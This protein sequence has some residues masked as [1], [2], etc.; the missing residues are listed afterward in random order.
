MSD[1]PPCD[2][3]LARAQQYAKDNGFPVWNYCPTLHCDENV[4][5]NHQFCYCQGMFNIPSNFNAQ[6][7][8]INGV[9]SLIPIASESCYCCCSC[10]AFDTPI[11][12]SKDM[13]KAVQNFEVNDLVWVAA[14]PTLKSWIQKPVLFS[15]GTGPDG[16]NKL[17]KVHFGDQTKGIVV[18]PDSFRSSFVSKEMSEKYFSILSTNKFIDKG[19]LVDLMAVKKSDAD[20][21]CK[22]LGSQMVVAQKVFNILKTDSNYLLVTGIQPFLMKDKTLKQAQKLVP[23][24]DVLMLAD[25]STTPIISLELGMFHKGVHHIATSNHPATSL[26]GHLLLANGIVVGDYATQLSMGSAKSSLK[27]THADLPVFG[28]KEYSAKYN[29]LDSTSFSA[30]AKTPV[31]H[32]AELFE[33]FHIAKSALIPEDAFSF[34]TKDQSEELM[35]NAPIYPASNNVAEPDVRYLFKLFGAFNPDITY[36]Y[37]QNNMIPNAYSFNQYGSKFVVINCGWTLLE[38]I[39]FQGIAMTIAHL[40]AALNEDGLLPVGVSPLGKADYDVYPVFLS[41]FY[42]PQAAVLNYNAASDQIKKIFSYIKKHRDPIDEISL[43]CRIDTLAASIKGSPL[44]HCAG[45]PPNPAL[46]VT[47]ASATIPEGHEIP[48]I[49]ITFNMPVDEDTASALGNYMF[50]PAALVFLATVDKKNPA[51]VNIEGIIIPDTDYTVVVTGVLSVDQQP[52]IVGK[53]GAKFKLS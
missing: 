23:G 5:Y 3:S 25:G 44:P 43:D 7:Q 47:G 37:D 29:N 19:G 49:A 17:I 50:N 27:D 26:D 38:G 30:Y 16:Q 35:L 10:F 8:C 28:S 48:V 1:F 4:S 52:I 24:K 21:I 53:N 15:S 11:A 6:G 33:V 36:Y 32:E 46:E 18:T 41:V 45:G 14:D 12:V 20:K 31:A 2:A 9:G 40:T 39:Y 42:N 22:L 13:V 51:Q 34:I